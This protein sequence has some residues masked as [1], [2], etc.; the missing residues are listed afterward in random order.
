MNNKYVWVVKYDGYWPAEIESI[1]STEERAEARLA[2]L[3]EKGQDEWEIMRW[4]IDKVLD[5][6]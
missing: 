4:P 3:E 2:E 6:A 5:D 1:W